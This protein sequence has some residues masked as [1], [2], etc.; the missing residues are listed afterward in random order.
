MTTQSTSDRSR[1]ANQ[2]NA[3][4]STG[5]RSRAGKARSSMNA[6]CHGL[7]LSIWSDPA[8][9]PKKLLSDRGFHPSIVH[10]RKLSVSIFWRLSKR[11]LDE[12]LTTTDIEEINKI[13]YSAQ[14]KDVETLV[15]LLG[16]KALEIARL[17]RYE[18][19]AISRRKS[20]I[21]QFDALA[22]R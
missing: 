22:R 17:D 3:K 15:F 5:P 18:R 11:Y 16:E 21:R 6:L 7:N 8:L 4:L 13:L 9:A 2:A 12:R 10:Y 14:L 20:A 1:R 19:R